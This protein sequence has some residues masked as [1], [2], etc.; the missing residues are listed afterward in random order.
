M[1]KGHCHV[2]NIWYIKHTHKGDYQWHLNTLI[3]ITLD[4]R[5]NVGVF[6]Y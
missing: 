1:D 3:A 2:E 5:N 6:K 4:Q